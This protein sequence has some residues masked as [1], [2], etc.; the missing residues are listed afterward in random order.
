MTVVWFQLLPLALVVGLLAARR[1]ALLSGAAGLATTTVMVL[2]TSSLGGAALVEQMLRGAWLA[3]HAIAVLVAG[4]FFQRGL[5]AVRAPTGAEGSEA[6]ARPFRSESFNYRAAYFA[7][8]LVGP[9]AESATGFG[10]GYV[11][12]LSLLLR[13]GVPGLAAVVL[14]LFSQILVPWGALAVGTKI[15][16]HLAGL[17]EAALG[18]GSALATIP[19]LCGHLACFWWLLHRFSLPVPRAAAVEDIGWTAATAGMLLLANLLLAVDIAAIA[20][21][22]PLLVLRYVRDVRPSR[23]RLIADIRANAGYIALA[24]VLLGSRLIPGLEAILWAGPVLRPFDGELPFPIFLNPSL[25][26]L[27][28]PL[29]LFVASGRLGRLPETVRASLG[30]A[31]R[32]AAV[33]LLFVV[34]A[35]LFA[36]SGM[37]ADLAT[38]FHGAVGT[39]A[40]VA[41]PAFAG[42]AGALTGSN[43]GSNGIMMPIQSA[44]ATRVAVDG[45]WMASLQNTVG[46]AFTMLSPIRISLGCALVAAPG[47]EGR[48]YR[49]GAVIGAVVLAIG[50]ALSMAALALR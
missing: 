5:E 15:G 4:T 24:T 16:A 25:W 2:S 37:A 12:A 36:A 45:A 35:H 11:I 39:L 17:P 34:M 46:S 32:P 31:W 19:L 29:A 1:G 44:L 20:A 50:T 7:C 49:A 13:M 26:L 30:L 41:T 10:V 22:G 3:W 27:A 8:F 47:M 18:A 28:V 6:G 48:V 42:L 14:G 40:I 23:R 21:L 43:T 9:F 38:S 33:T